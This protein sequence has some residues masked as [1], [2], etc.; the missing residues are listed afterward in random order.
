MKHI[1]GNQNH[2]DVKNLHVLIF[3][4]K[5]LLCINARMIYHLLKPSYIESVPLTVMVKLCLPGMKKS[6]Q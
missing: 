1:N 2:C 6:P 3:K 5:A 4:K